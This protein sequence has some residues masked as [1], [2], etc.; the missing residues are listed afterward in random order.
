MRVFVA[1]LALFVFVP[2]VSFADHITPD[3]M[4]GYYTEDGH[5]SSDGMGG[6]YRLVAVSSG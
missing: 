6:Y 2:A 1:A 5:A 3:G 4:G